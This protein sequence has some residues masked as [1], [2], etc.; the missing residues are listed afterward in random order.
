MAEPT[1]EI[2]RLP[3]PNLPHDSS[4][5]GGLLQAP[6][7]KMGKSSADDAV[8]KARFRLNK[9]R[10]E[11]DTVDISEWRA[12]SKHHNALDGLTKEIRSRVGVDAPLINNAWAKFYEVLSTFGPSLLG[13]EEQDSATLR[14]MHLCEC[15]GGFVAA[16]NVYL[17]L[18]RPR[19]DWKWMGA[20]LN[21]YY[22]G[23]DLEQMVD[24]DA[25]YRRT[26]DRWWT[27]PDG[28]GNILQ[29]G[30]AQDLWRWYSCRAPEGKCQLV[31]ADGSM[32]VQYA[33]NKQESLCLPLIVRELILAIGLLGA[34]GSCVMKAYSLLDDSTV[35]AL[36][37]A[38]SMFDK[39]EIVK[40]AASKPANSETYWVCLGF[41]G[42][43]KDDAKWLKGFLGLQ[44]PT[45]ELQ[46]PS[47]PGKGLG[48]FI[49]A[50]Q[51]AAVSLASR[52]ASAIEGKLARW[53]DVEDS[54]P[55]P[56]TKRRKTSSS[57]I[58]EYVSKLLPDKCDLRSV[59]PLLSS[60][61]AGRLGGVDSRRVS[62]GTV[63][64]RVH[65]HDEDV[66]LVGLRK[67][68]PSGAAF[69]LTSVDERS[70]GAPRPTVSPSTE[71]PELIL[72]T[73]QIS[74]CPGA[75]RRMTGF[76]SHN[77]RKI[78]TSSSVVYSPLVWNAKEL[79]DLVRKRL[80]RF[81]KFPTIPPRAIGDA[82][83]CSLTLEECRRTTVSELLREHVGIDPD[84]VST[85]DSASHP[86][87][88]AGTAHVSVRALRDPTIFVD[89]FYSQFD[90]AAR[91]VLL[92]SA[93]EGI[94]ALA[95]DHSSVL[96]LEIGAAPVVAVWVGSVVF[97]L[98]EESGKI[99]WSRTLA[100]ASDTSVLR[101]SS[102][103]VCIGRL[104]GGRAKSSLRAL[105]DSL[106]A[107]DVSTPLAPMTCTLYS[108]FR[109]WLGDVNET[110][111]RNQARYWLTSPIEATSRTVAL[112]YLAEQG[113]KRFTFENA[114]TTFV[115]VFFGT[116]DPIHENHWAVVEHALSNG[117]V[118]SVILV[119]NAE[120]NPSKP[121]ASALATRQEL[122]RERV[123]ASDVGDRVS[124]ASGYSRN[125]QRWADR[126]ALAHAL[127]GDMAAKT[128][129]IL[130]PMILCGEDSFMKALKGSTRDKT[131][132][133]FIGLADLDTSILVFPRS[134]N[135]EPLKAA[136]EE[137]PPR[138]R[139]KVSVA[140]DYSD[141]YPALSST[142]IRSAIA[143]APEGGVTAQ[144]A[145]RVPPVRNMTSYGD[146]ESP[147]RPRRI[148]LLYT[149]TPTLVLEFAKLNGK[150][151][152]RRMPL[153]R[154]DAQSDPE[155]IVQRLRKRFR[156]YLPRHLISDE[157]LLGLVRRL[158]DGAPRSGKEQQIESE[159]RD[160][161]K[162][163]DD[164]LQ[165][166]KAQMEVTFKQN[167]VRP[168]DPEFVYDIEVSFDG[169]AEGGKVNDWDE[170][171]E[172]EEVILWLR[173][174]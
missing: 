33:P 121:K 76:D 22:E 167:Q 162:L 141:P 145:I 27:G 163:G 113:L 29:A 173:Y 24:D 21:P 20:S 48:E 68:L 45:R 46:L 129:D 114:K 37:L 10:D 86:A 154:L 78:P 19:A 94:E 132:R 99:L 26:Q 34:G 61:T 146:D 75:Y 89:P 112:G 58:A 152:H 156:D 73:Q 136:V 158:R 161:N 95:M 50:A 88:A 119:A 140:E 144:I 116:F 153:P 5:L 38:G 125:S 100:P 122:L 35:A 169:G 82:V 41:R 3:L 137:V 14:T 40:P 60:D 150:L 44:D 17:S 31:T 36:C 69:T 139:R 151:Y 108:T 133:H 9:A 109:Q 171:S 59:K 30:A 159:E 87:P 74:D 142:R 165:K 166:V 149:P 6:S 81:D 77:N 83:T 85:W 111:L 106:A 160:L 101:S 164:K 168:D 71:W 4:L 110:C 79:K 7:Q 42:L 2:L 115:G 135:T 84:H 120:N 138:I 13:P 47:C 23:N 127:V 155:E 134:Q 54:D 63:T 93:I 96:L 39:I 128:T 32:D 8:E 117:L 55:H 157:Q 105:R 170:W 143:A 66:A 16:L 25:L 124:V 65:A 98:G 104:T 103:L 56:Y 64:D 12:F 57:S 72:T 80:I 107:G 126:E 28:S 90:P 147:I 91:K 123:I 52:Q 62:R 102:W 174:S 1:V 148:G 131:T 11:I 51:Q 53:R 43:A 67:K 15:P 130:V 70:T 92:E 118:S 172:A 97:R 18:T 49:V